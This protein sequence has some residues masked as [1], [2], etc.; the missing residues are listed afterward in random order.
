MATD[1]P[2]GRRGL[3]ANSLFSITAWL[4]PILI[5]F[6]S[7]PILVRNLGSEQ[8]GLLAIV[9]TF[10]AYSFAFGVG[11]VAGK[12]VPE[13]QTA[14]DP[15]KVTQ[16][17]AATFWFSLAI[18]VLGGSTLALLAPTI[19]RDILLISADHQD[20][21]VHAVYLACAIGLVM[22]LSQVFQFVLQG[23]H[24]F[25]SY[26]L[27]TNLNGLLLG[28]GN[29][30][31]ALNGYGIT[32]LLTWNLVVVSVTGV[33]F[34]LR[35]NHLLPSLRFVLDIPRAMVVSVVRYAG[36]IILYQIFGNALLLFERA[37]VMRKFG[38]EGLTYYFV[39]ML[40]AIYMHGFI[41]S[42]VQSI[43]P[44]VNESLD[45]PERVAG[46]YRRAS[47]IVLVIVAFSVTTFVACGALFLS[48]WVGPEL[49]VVAYPLL[50]PHGL[51]F[52]VIALG[53]MAFQLADAFK[54]PALNVI[55]TG[56]WMLLGIPL[57]I[58]GSDIWQSEGVAWARFAAA[59]VTFPIMAYTERR[60]LGKIQ[61]RFWTAVGARIA[62][63]V[64]LTGLVE[65]LVISSLRG[66][67]ISLVLAGGAGAIAY[68]AVLLV[69][70]YLTPDDRAVIKRSIFRQQIAASPAVI[71]E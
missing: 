41:S 37:W 26:A 71:V 25:D 68:A 62:I 17:I 4:F 65:W 52:G 16:V 53:I 38:P 22:M 5:G 59:L 6:V 8:Y 43:F 67:F 1:N 32:A 40:V 60:F 29:I 56:S 21:A 23:L 9:L 63:A 58:V 39:P 30:V 3:A 47:K 61:W 70:G 48:L 18:G 35:A 55:M 50:I 45:D 49:S 19:V 69:T 33:L 12:Y 42:L 34:Y 44:V 15:E 31:L 27:I 2:G 11:K 24:R 20:A 36:T 54:V 28:G 13:F 66:S 51:T 14:G 57:M 10:I 46:L 7:T 64:A